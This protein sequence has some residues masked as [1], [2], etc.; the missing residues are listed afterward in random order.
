MLHQPKCIKLSPALRDAFAQGNERLKCISS[1]RAI[2]VTESRDNFNSLPIL[3]IMCK[4]VRCL[5]HKGAAAWLKRDS[6]AERAIDFSHN[7]RQGGRRRRRVVRCSSQRAFLRESE[8]PMANPIAFVFVVCALKLLERFKGRQCA[9]LRN[10]NAL[11]IQFLERMCALKA[12]RFQT[13][14]T[15]RIQSC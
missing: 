8:M 2:G 3:E 6:L 4:A 14:L 7:A 5:L 1:A 10:S 12:T 15:R 13:G 9:H 11:C